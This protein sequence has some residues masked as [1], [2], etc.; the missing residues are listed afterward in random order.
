MDKE[1]G[2]GKISEEEM[3]KLRRQDNERRRADLFAVIDAL[4]QKAGKPIT[5]ILEE[6]CTPKGKDPL[7]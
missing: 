2:A 5:Q 3:N 7:A 4:E 6:K 1:E